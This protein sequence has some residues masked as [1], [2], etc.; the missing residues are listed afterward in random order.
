MKRLTPGRNR[1]HKNSTKIR[2]QERRPGAAPAAAAALTS[3]FF[4]DIWSK[5]LK[6]RILQKILSEKQMGQRFLSTPTY[7]PSKD[8]RKQ[9]FVTSKAHSDFPALRRFRITP[10]IP[11][12]PV[13][14]NI[15]VVG[16][17]TSL[18]DLQPVQKKK[19]S[20]P[21]EASVTLVERR[22]RRFGL[23]ALAALGDAAA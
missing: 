18:G 10:A 8:L 1:S 2:P 16:S 13:P 3:P 20:C 23:A 14:S 21:P 4:Q 5:S 12:R 17:G 6:S 15:I 9:L 11:A 19:L 7:L 22:R